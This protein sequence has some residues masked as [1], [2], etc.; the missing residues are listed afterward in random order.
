MAPYL[1][2]HIAHAKG[3]ASDCLHPAAPQ[4]QRSAGSLARQLPLAVQLPPVQLPVSGRTL[5]RHVS[6]GPGWELNKEGVAQQISEEP[7]TSQAAAEAAPPAEV[8]LGVAVPQLLGRLGWGMGCCWWLRCRPL[9]VR[10]RLLA[11][12]DT[13]LRMCS[14]HTHNPCSSLA[15]PHPPPAL[16]LLPCRCR[17]GTKGRECRSGCAA[18]LWRTRLTDTRCRWVLAQPVVVLRL[19]ALWFWTHWAPHHPSR[20]GHPT[21]PYYQSS[22]C[23]RSRLAFARLASQ[24][25]LRPPV[26]QDAGSRRVGSFSLFAPG[27]THIPVMYTHG[28][29]TAP[30]RRMRCCGER[31]A[32]RRTPRC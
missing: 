6:L 18:T 15:S 14:T 23:I 22:L 5:G 19:C 8:G 3:T 17:R 30:R 27:F 20:T 29:A 21:A 10:G 1:I 31:A 4:R 25:Q 12:A 11:W 32:C 26:L 16:V 24:Q 28:A 13:P 2:S 7:S 9:G